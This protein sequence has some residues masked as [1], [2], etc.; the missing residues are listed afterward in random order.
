[1]T[2]RPYL[3]IG[4]PLIDLAWAAQS[5]SIL[6]VSRRRQGDAVQSSRQ[7]ADAKT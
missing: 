1:V 2:L 3:L 4:L 5:Q 7:V 6:I